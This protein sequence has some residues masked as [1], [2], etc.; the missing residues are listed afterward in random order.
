MCR[1]NKSVQENS[2]V[3]LR[4]KAFCDFSRETKRGTAERHVYRENEE[5]RKWSQTVW[6]GTV[7]KDDS[8]LSLSL[9]LFLTAENFI[10]REIF[11]AALRVPTF[12]PLP[13]GQKEREKPESLTPLS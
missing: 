7:I 13:E 1:V 12:D 4:Y 2:S 9:S 8:L 11:H 5:A 6:R 10:R 3:L